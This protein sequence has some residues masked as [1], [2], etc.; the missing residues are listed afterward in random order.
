MSYDKACGYLELIIG[1]MWAKKSKNLAFKIST[2]ADYNMK[3]LFINHIYDKRSEDEDTYDDGNFS[4][5]GSSSFILSSKIDRM[6]IDN[7]LDVHVDAYDAIAIDECQFFG[8][9][10]VTEVKKWVN[11]KHKVVICAGLDGDANCRVFGH[12]LFLIPL[13]D[14]VEKLQAQCAVCLYELQKTGFCGI[15]AVLANAPFSARITE[16]SGDQIQ[17]GGK[18]SYTPMCRYHHQEHLRLSL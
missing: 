6:K 13:A 5:H 2:Y 18:E 7:L 4:Q 14:K 11:E 17:P 16:N 15:E 3:C 8:E 12:T 1:P 10:L 9:D